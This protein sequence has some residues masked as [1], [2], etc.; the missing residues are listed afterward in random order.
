MPE[1]PEVETTRLGI[2]PHVVGKSILEVI[3]R[4]WDLRWPV[5]PELPGVEGRRFVSVGRRSKYLLLGTDG[6]RP[7]M[8]HLGM[9][10]S[11]RVVSPAEEWRKHDHIAISVEGGLQL[12]YHDPRRFGL[13]MVVA[14]AE[15]EAH[16]LL[17]NLGPEP[18]G[19]DFTGRYLY[20]TLRRKKVA[21]KV[22]L[23][24]AKVVVGVGN[25][26]A[27]E[28]LF[29]AGIHPAL[30]AGKLTRPK[31]ERLVAAIREVPGGIHSPGRDDAAGFPEQRRAAG[32]FRA[33]AFRL[34]AEGGAVPGVRNCHFTQSDGAAGDILVRGLPGEVMERGLSVQAPS[35]AAD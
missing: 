28:S 14:D 3:V 20:D 30:A 8:I 13:V 4:R 27:S 18:L 11:L 33:A 31:A 35:L 12:R 9:S 29:R 17:A 19:E 16:P 1:L 23:M 24:D 7:V 32:V 21:L 10:G 5:S 22:A 2:S 25:I 15:L 6:G 34:R 26:Y